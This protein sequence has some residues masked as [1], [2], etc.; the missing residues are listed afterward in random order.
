M[1]KRLLSMALAAVFCV[2]TYAYE[3]G[4]YMFTKDARLKVAGA[5][6]A[7]NDYNQTDNWSNE[8]GGPLAANWKVVAIAGPDGSNVTALQSQGASAEEGTALTSAWQLQ[9][10]IYAISFYV[11]SPA[12]ASISISAGGN[13]FMSLTSG[14]PSRQINAVATLAEAAWTQVCRQW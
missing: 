9:N 1:K 11:Y 5:N 13:N 14:D 10:G 2:G 3:V 8:N 6:I 7:S 12:A 4:D